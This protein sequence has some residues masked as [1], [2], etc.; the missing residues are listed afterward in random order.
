MSD[1]IR[2]WF[3]GRSLR[4]K[5][6]ILVMLALLV[7]TVI[8]G[9]II[10]PVG[11]GLSAARERHVPVVLLLADTR[12]RAEA[13]RALRRGG[14]GPVSGPLDAAVRQSADAAGF[15]LATLDPADGGAV[16]F[17]ITSARGGALLAWLTQLEASGVVVDQLVTANNGDRTVSAQVTV[18]SRGR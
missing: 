18:R 14:A 13:I 9:L 4:E 16:R 17:T 3:N 7:V 11:D 12:D 1:R 2:L 15:A 5:R 6:M 8:W 10:R